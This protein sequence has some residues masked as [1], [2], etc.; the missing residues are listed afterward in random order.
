MQDISPLVLLQWKHWSPGSPPEGLQVA[1]FNPGAAFNPE[2]AA[3]GSGPYLHVT[4]VP[5]WG[6]Y[7]G[8]HAKANDYHIMFIGTAC[9][10]T[11][12]RVQGLGV[13]PNL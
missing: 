1:E 13:L 3:V 9:L 12:F 6:A 4:G 11:G 7:L 8:A 5:A 10:C 2:A